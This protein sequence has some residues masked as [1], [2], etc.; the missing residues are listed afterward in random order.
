MARLPAIRPRK[1]QAER[2]YSEPYHLGLSVNQQTENTVQFIVILYTVVESN[3]DDEARTPGLLTE[4]TDARSLE[5]NRLKTKSRTTYANF[6]S[7][8]RN[9]F[10][11]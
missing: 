4:V 3:I 2:R 10:C 7:I 6:L 5:N 8:A 11:L 9:L 1:K